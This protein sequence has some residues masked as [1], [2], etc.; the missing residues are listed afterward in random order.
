MN[1][2]DIAKSTYRVQKME[3][4]FD[5]V[6]NAKNSNSEQ[7]F[8][9]PQLQKAIAELSSYYSDGAWLHDYELDEK[10]LLPPDL[11]RGV[12]SQD[13]LYNLLCDLRELYH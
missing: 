9:K 7:I 4:L 6:S 10:R 11:K 3:E 13:E 1:L 8:N 5:V 2:D 12:L